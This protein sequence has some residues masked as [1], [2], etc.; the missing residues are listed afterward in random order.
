MSDISV[1]GVA[2]G[3]YEKLIETLMQKE[4]V[5]RDNA[6]EK[7]K[8]YEQ[9]TALWQKIDRFSYT[10]RDTSRS[11]YSFNNPFVEKN[12]TTS[13]ESALTATA[14]RDAQE[15][16]FK[17][18]ID[19]VAK[20]DSFLSGEIA[21]DYKIPQGQYTFNVG[22]K[23]FSINWKGGQYRNFIRQVNKHGNGILRI[24]EVKT[25]G[26]NYSL[27]FESQITGAE[28]RLTFSDDALPF[29]VMNDLLKENNGSAVEISIPEK[30]IEANTTTRIPFHGQL[31]KD[32]PHTLE[33]SVKI[34]THS[35]SADDQQIAA[36]QTSDTQTNTEKVGTIEYSGIRVSNEP[37][38]SDIPNLDPLPSKKDMQNEVPQQETEDYN[39]VSLIAKNGSLIPLPPLENKNDVQVFTIPLAQYG[40]IQG[41]VVHNKNTHKS[42]KIETI[43]VSNHQETEDYIPVH[44]V[45]RA[46]DA[47]FTFEGITITRKNNDIDDLIAGVTLHLADKT[48][49][50]ETISIKPN[51][52]AAKNAII[53]L[54]AQYNRLLAEI[55][56]VTSNQQAV[57]EEIAYF[58]D[59]EKETAQENLG[60]MFGDSTLTS[61]KNKLRHIV[62]NVYRQNEDTSIRSLSEIGISTKSDTGSGIN[63]AQLR[64]YLEI[65][66]KKL[67]EA[68]KTSMTDV[69]YLF[70]YDTDNDRLADNGVGVQLF[71]Q[72][73]PYIQRGGIFSG[74]TNAI[75]AQMRLTNNRIE[76]YDKQLEKKEAALRKKYGAMDGALQRLQK[77]SGMIEN[78]NRQNKNN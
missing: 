28:N 76:R 41:I 39:I 59:E 72:I 13:N 42:V 38:M 19:S 73:D 34:E 67:D 68:L 23:S 24:S 52:E 14:S 69:R 22:E 54:V 47:V 56:I 75:S 4:R 20:P 48:D 50:K 30:P 61:F 25:T 12:V 7:L 21:R 36:T 17:I 78:F 71:N 32:Q 31:P 63:A 10:V 64:G 70:G 29:A 27:L 8:K 55:N 26:K 77:Q 1:P 46:Q 6:A 49:K 53:E 44:P 15:Q 16:D 33:Y 65:N 9:Q 66:E 45:S 35:D 57:I 18:S 37:S 2:G 74:K 62:T 40:D 3:K 5:P 58:T 60:T 43:A 51:T 11:L